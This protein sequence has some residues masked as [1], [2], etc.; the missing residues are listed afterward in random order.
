MIQVFWC[1]LFTSVL[2]VIHRAG[3]SEGHEYLK[4][5]VEDD[6]CNIYALFAE[7]I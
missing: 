1:K 2:I 4:S 7:S 3:G 6:I 5:E